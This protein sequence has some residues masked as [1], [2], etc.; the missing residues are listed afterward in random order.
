MSL[1]VR[2]YKKGNKFLLISLKHLMIE[3]TLTSGVKF[4]TKMLSDVKERIEKFVYPK[5]RREAY[6]CVLSGFF[7]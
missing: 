1:R 7:P 4:E 6:S 2:I 5:H 3:T